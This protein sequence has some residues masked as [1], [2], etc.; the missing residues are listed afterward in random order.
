MGRVIEANRSKP[1][2]S[3]E[4]QTRCLSLPARTSSQGYQG[5]GGVSGEGEK[6]EKK[7]KTRIQ[8]PILPTSTK[9]QV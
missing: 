4:P 7:R 1:M 2:M 3:P 9:M 6:E 8:F 5:G